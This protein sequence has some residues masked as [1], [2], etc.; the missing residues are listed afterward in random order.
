ME[1][2]SV[3]CCSRSATGEASRR[4]DLPALIVGLGER[5]ERALERA[6]LR[7]DDDCEAVEEAREFCS[8]EAEATASGPGTGS[9]KYGCKLRPQAPGVPR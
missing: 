6:C 8:E 9:T 2:V 1:N 7:R 5:D 3:E 4:G